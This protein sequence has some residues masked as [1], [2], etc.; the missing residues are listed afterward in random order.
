MLRSYFNQIVETPSISNLLK[1][2]GSDR[3]VSV[4]FSSLLSLLNLHIQKFRDIRTL[5]S[6]VFLFI[7][8]KKLFIY[9]FFRRLL[10]LKTDINEISFL[11]VKR[12]WG[13]HFPKKEKK[14]FSPFEHR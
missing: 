13:R 1:Q 12:M 14:K 3:A 11:K 10:A 7:Y 9:L 4:E 6:N 8:F 2:K 5:D